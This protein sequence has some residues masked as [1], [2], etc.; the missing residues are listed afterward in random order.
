[1]RIHTNVMAEVV[2]ILPSILLM[3]FSEDEGERSFM[4]AWLIFHLEIVWGGK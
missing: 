1:M 4:F 3:Q 2:A